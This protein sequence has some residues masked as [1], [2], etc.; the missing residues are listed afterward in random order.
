MLVGPVFRAELVRTARRQRYYLLR[1]AYGFALLLLIWGDYAA[2]VELAEGRGSTPSIAEIADFAVRTFGSFAGF[3]LATI[4]VLVPP[5]FGAVIADEKQRKTIHYLMASQLSSGEIVFDKLAAR[6]LHVGV[7]I[8]LGLPVISLLTLFGGVAWEYVVVA[9][10]GTCSTTFFAAAMATLVSTFA[11][12]VRQ[13]V[14]IAYV[15]EFAWLIVPSVA[16]PLCRFAFPRVYLW[17]RPVNDWVQATSPLFVLFTAARRRMRRGIF[18]GGT[19]VMLDPFL[20]MVGL[21]LAAGVF[22]LLVAMMQLRPTFRRQETSARRLAWFG[23]R[24]RPSR[25]LRR[26]ACGEDAML[27]KERHCV[28]TDVF[29]K[30]F[31]LPA[32][33]IL[34]VGV[35][36]ASGLDDNVVRCFNELVRTG[37]PSPSFARSELNDTLRAISPYSIALWL[38]AVAGA[39]AS[40]V[41]GE[42]EEDTWVSLLSTPLSGWEILRGKGLGAVWDLRGLGAL[43]G[44]F[45]LI[46][47]AAGGVHPLG[48]LLALL[49]VALLTWFVVTLGMYVSLSAR[50]TSRA[51]TT[52]I[53]VLVFLNGGYFVIL[54]PVLMI[55][56]SGVDQWTYSHLGCTPYL[57]AETLVSFEWVAQIRALGRVPGLLWLTLTPPRVYGLLILAGYAVAAAILTWRVVWRFDVVTDRPR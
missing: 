33:I 48:F 21:Q 2:L 19:G 50:T 53:V 9:Y 14:L 4:L 37:Y 15:L 57:A 17:F 43:L 29:T 26:P 3:Q 32:T 51:I 36:L 22:F 44:L 49:V 7:F 55:F 23:P 5:L 47:L 20:W 28:R 42:R 34:T 38:L 8:L 12:R 40:R 11:R 6:L 10:V 35:I 31:V 18:L 39:T 54:E 1:V 27:W 24:Q 41:T 30:L 16:D 25:W 13:G 45:W 56:G 46:V 52:V